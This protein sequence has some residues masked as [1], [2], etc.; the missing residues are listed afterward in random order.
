MQISLCAARGATP[1]PAAAD[2]FDSGT[3]NA[4]AKAAKITKA[5]KKRHIGA[6]IAG[7][8]ASVLVVLVV[9]A[10]MA[11]R[12]VCIR[13][14]EHGATTPGTSSKDHEACSASVMKSQ[15][16]P[17]KTAS[18]SFTELSQRDSSKVMPPKIRNVSGKVVVSSNR[19][20]DQT[21]NGPESTISFMYAAAYPTQE[22]TVESTTGGTVGHL[23]QPSM[24]GTASS[25][26]SKRMEYAQYQIDSLAGHEIL[27]GLILDKS[28]HSR[29]TGGMRLWSTCFQ[30][31]IMMP[32]Y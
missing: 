14:G 23:E 25:N 5:S 16:V 3:Q 2:D 22:F 31:F 32:L 4:T 17:V 18:A 15:A 28:V 10:L 30:S 26:I 24:A 20:A 11:L 6:I 13:Q 1:V 12:A 9:V 27:D 19:L 7:T 8:T 29:L 21:L